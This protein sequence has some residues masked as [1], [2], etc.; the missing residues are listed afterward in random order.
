MHLVINN[1]DLING[2]IDG[3]VHYNKSDRNK[4]YCIANLVGIETICDQSIKLLQTKC[5]HYKT[6][7]NKLVIILDLISYSF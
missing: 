4:F 6:F 3:A 1:L 7:I 5:I 2:L